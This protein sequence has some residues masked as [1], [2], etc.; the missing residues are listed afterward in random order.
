MLSTVLVST[1]GVCSTAWKS[2]SPASIALYAKNPRH[3]HD[4]S[5]VGIAGLAAQCAARGRSSF[6]EQS[7]IALPI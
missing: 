3:L 7:H 4:P 1:P 2:K 6:S 5:V